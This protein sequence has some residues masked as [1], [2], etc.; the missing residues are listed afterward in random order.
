MNLDF[1]AGLI[2]A[3][4][5]LGLSFEFIKNKKT[6]ILQYRRK[7]VLDITNKDKAVLEQVVKVLSFGRVVTAGSVFAYRANS[8]R[9][10]QKFVDLFENRFHGSAKIEMPLFKQ[11]L[12]LCK[13]DT[14]KPGFVKFVHLMYGS[15]T[16]GKTRKYTIDYWLNIFEGTYT[17]DYVDKM[18]K[19][20]VASIPMNG[21]YV[22]GYTQGD[23]SFNLSSKTRLQANFTLTDPEESVLLKIKD[24]LQLSDGCV[25]PINPKTTK[26]NR[27][28]YR[29]QLDRTKKTIERIIP[30]FDKFP[31]YGNQSKRYDLYKKGVLILSAKANGY[32]AAFKEIA[33]KFK[34]LKEK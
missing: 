34:D 8:Y 18:R 33:S 10:I 14:S 19:N 23:G 31:V 11:A 1:I 17:P 26:N 27:I 7:L 13:A 32:E 9:D 20:T 5:S 25:I 29:L 3:D 24:F 2:D 21:S 16:Q 12:K 30:H 4:G 6:N 28:C 15:N 22:S